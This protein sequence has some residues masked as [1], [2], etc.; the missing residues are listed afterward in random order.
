MYDDK[1]MA[2]KQTINQMI[3]KGMVNEAY[4][5]VSQ[6]IKTMPEDADLNELLSTIRHLKKTSEEDNKNVQVGLNT[7]SDKN[8]MNGID[9][10]TNTENAEISKG[11][12]RVLFIAYFFPPLSGSGVQRPVKFIKYLRDFGWEPVVL[13]VQ[14]SD[15]ELKD[16]AMLQEIPKDI[17][18]IRIPADSKINNFTV[19]R[20]F[21]YYKE[22]CDPKLFNEI[23]NNLTKQQNVDIRT[24]LWPDPTIL[25]VDSVLTHLDKLNLDSYDCIFSTSGP[26]SS[27]IL[28]YM[29]KKK[30]GKPWIA[31]FRDE[32]SNNPLIAHVDKNL[33]GFRILRSFEK[34]VVEYCDGMT[35]ISD[36]M[37]ANYINDFNVP[38]NKVKSITNGYDEADF[39]SITDNA[40]DE[41]KFV[42][43]HN[44]ILYQREPFKF[45]DAVSELINNKKISRDKIKVYLGKASFGDNDD[46][47]LQY[48]NKRNLSDIFVMDYL[49][50]KSSIIRSAKA[51]LLLL[52][53]GQG[54]EWKGVLTGKIFEY[55]RLC[56]PI[57]NLGYKDSLAAMLIQELDRGITVELN[58][59]QRIYQAILHYYE[60]WDNKALPQY[61]V[62]KDVEKFERKNLT[63]ALAS[64]LNSIQTSTRSDE[65]T[66]LNHEIEEA[67]N[68]GDT[69]KAR[70]LIES[71]RNKFGENAEYISM[72]AVFYEYIGDYDRALSCMKKGIAKFENISDLLYNSGYIYFEQKNYKLAYIYFCLTNYF[73]NSSASRN[74]VQYYLNA[75]SKICDLSFYSEMS[76]TQAKLF[77]WIWTRENNDLHNSIDD[78]ADKII[79]NLYELSL[80]STKCLSVPWAIKRIAMNLLLNCVKYK[81]AA[82]TDTNNEFMIKIIS[83]FADLKDSLRKYFKINVAICGIGEKTLYIYNIISPESVSIKAFVS[84]DSHMNKIGN[85]PIISSSSLVQE[86]Y[87]YLIIAE[88]KDVRK[89]SIQDYSKIIDYEAYW[90]LISTNHHNWCVYINEL[91][92]INDSEGLVLGISYRDINTK[93]F[94]KKICNIAASG[95]DLYYDLMLLRQVLA[96]SGPRLKYCIITLAKYSFEYDLSL[97]SQSVI[98]PYYYYRTNSIHNYKDTTQ[99]EQIDRINLFEDVIFIEN[100]TNRFALNYKDLFEQEL[101]LYNNRQFDSS[102]LNNDLKTKLIAQMQKDFNKDYPQTVQE[103]QQIFEE[104]MKLL[105]ENQIK[106]IVVVCPVTEFYRRNID[107]DRII[108]EFEKIITSFQNRYEFQY[109][110]YFESS[111][112]EESDFMD[113]SHLNLK[114][115]EKFTRLLD[116]EII[117]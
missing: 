104:I 71:Y 56:K 4:D 99:K 7:D 47:Y 80:V 89:L 83:D 77:Y 20:L 97:S 35:V 91:E 33:L 44:G 86:E 39:S 46:H 30:C 60:L 66:H 50:H 42:I 16:F 1:L 67:L 72:Q 95:Q 52:I 10:K 92:Q 87:D 13:T 40:S 5:K 106:P 22:V 3:E 102:Y 21:T 101:Y 9:N 32:W 49:D 64:F 61:K 36:Q 103:N 14:D 76:S 70:F 98:L 23:I 54:K 53:T 45:I 82:E 15:F 84:D 6:L 51:S 55:L 94:S 17:E 25:W 68:K 115:A 105:K 27:H 65:I 108:A 116:K 26:Y 78:N 109:L 12:K 111:L 63:G 74:D 69:E 43:V 37:K 24:V 110:D 48:I 112:F 107:G 2:L 113:Y 96:A 57:L 18:I 75:L 81:S 114:G 90:N 88:S 41:K 11:K 34:S 73:F 100:H 93:Y 79:N 117:W 58:D 85:V 28:G 31:D 62:T 8:F 38:E 29:L 19:N 59:E